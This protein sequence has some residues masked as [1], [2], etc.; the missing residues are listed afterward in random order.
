MKNVITVINGPNLNLLGEREPEIYGSMTLADI[1]AKLEEKAAEK[2]FKIKAFQSNGE[3]R[4]IDYIHQIKEK[5]AGLIINP[6]ALTHYSYSLQDALAVL[7]C[8]IIEVHLSNIYSRESF[9]HQSL[10][11]P[12]ARGQISGLGYRGYL[13]ALDAII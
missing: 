8:P 13:Y 5:T 11:A 7:T 10:I 3:G 9:R 1:I 2:G 4:I 6:G 12:L